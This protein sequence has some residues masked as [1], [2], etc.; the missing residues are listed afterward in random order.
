MAPDW[1]SSATYC[2][3]EPTPDIGLTVVDFADFFLKIQA[4]FAPR[5]GGNLVSK[6]DFSLHLPVFIKTLSIFDP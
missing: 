6:A 5:L 1:S 3:C 2:L 4:K